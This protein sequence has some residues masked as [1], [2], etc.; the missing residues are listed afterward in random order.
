MLRRFRRDVYSCHALLSM[1]FPVLPSGVFSL[2][3]PP[4]DCSF[5]VSCVGERP[6]WPI[7]SPNKGRKRK[8]KEERE[9]RSNILILDLKD[10]KL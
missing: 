6:W 10:G 5:L 7:K 9:L 8:G 3:M 2:P 4:I 1:E